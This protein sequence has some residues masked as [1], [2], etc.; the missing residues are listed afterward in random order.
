[1]VASTHAY[2][3]VITRK[4]D[5]TAAARERLISPAIFKAR[6]IQIHPGPFSAGYF[7][8]HVASLVRREK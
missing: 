7:K 3:P 4:T 2:K 8:A 6:V 1:M 5:Q